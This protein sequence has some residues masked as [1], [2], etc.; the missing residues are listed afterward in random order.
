[1]AATIAT[2]WRL[3][4]PATAA[5]AQLGLARV[6]AAVAAQSL[7]IAAAAAAGSSSSSS[8]EGQAA[9]AVAL[10]SPPLRLAAV[11][12]AGA[13]AAAAGRVAEAAAPVASSPPILEIEVDD[14]DTAVPQAIAAGAALAQRVR[15]GVATKSALLA[16]PGLPSIAIA[17]VQRSPLR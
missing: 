10:T 11:A 12:P 6:L 4:L 1:M 2:H 15:Y 8:A 17:L 16:V 7:P 13:A 9:A 5:D 3:L 14:L